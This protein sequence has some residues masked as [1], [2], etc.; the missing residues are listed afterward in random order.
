AWLHELLARRAAPGPP[1]PPTPRPERLP[2]SFA[3]ARLWFLEQ[4]HGPGPAYNLPFA[5]RLRG[6]LDAGALTAALGDVVGRH[7]SLRTVFAVAGGQPYQRVIPAGQA[8][9]PV[10]VTAAAPGELAGL[11]E[12]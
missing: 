1:L 5:W 3:Q 12:A 9:V 2:L 7:E 4:F 6:R 10:A 8:M 11:V